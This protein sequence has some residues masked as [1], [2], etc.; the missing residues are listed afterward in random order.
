MMNLAPLFLL[1][2][3]CSA[4]DASYDEATSGKMIQLS[5][6]IYDISDADFEA[7]RYPTCYEGFNV[8]NQLIGS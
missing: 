4:Q 1:V 5:T 2:L 3:L 6:S 8:R 7:N